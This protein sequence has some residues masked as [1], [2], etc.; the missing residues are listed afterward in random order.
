[1]SDFRQKLQI[2]ISREP[3]GILRGVKNPRLELDES[4]K[5]SNGVMTLRPQPW[6]LQSDKYDFDPSTLTRHNSQST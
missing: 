5:S 3:C 6:A 2:V 1:M 4:H